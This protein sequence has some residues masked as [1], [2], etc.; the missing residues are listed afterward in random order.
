VQRGSGEAVEDAV[1][2]DEVANA[3]SDSGMTGPSRS[4]MQR[5]VEAKRMHKEI[6]SRG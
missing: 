6:Q 5:D 4:M 2:H 3:G 1:V